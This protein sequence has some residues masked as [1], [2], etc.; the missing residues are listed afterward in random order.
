VLDEQVEAEGHAPLLG[1]IDRGIIDTCLA[2]GCID[3][4]ALAAALRVHRSTVWRRIKRLLANAATLDRYGKTLLGD[5][6]PQ[7]WPVVM[8]MARTL[9]GAPGALDLD[10]YN[11]LAAIYRAGAAAH[12][13]LHPTI[14]AAEPRGEKLIISGPGPLLPVLAEDV[15]SGEAERV[16]PGPLRCR[17]CGRLVTVA[18]TGRPRRWCSDRCRKRHARAK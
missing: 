16:F 1:A 11:K 18:R 9:A 12:E 15:R 6:K 17:S 4:T 2:A 7:P 8:A 5:A 10:Q 3:Y 14:W 13:I